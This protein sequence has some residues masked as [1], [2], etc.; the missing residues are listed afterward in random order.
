MVGR[1]TDTRTAGEWTG[2]IVEYAI[3]SP[4]ESDHIRSLP[5]RASLVVD[6]AEG[7]LEVGGWKATTE[8]VAATGIEVDRE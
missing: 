6:T 3:E 1:R 8:D 4:N 2:P 5:V 7:P